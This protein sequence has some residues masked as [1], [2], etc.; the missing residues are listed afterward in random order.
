M[1]NEALLLDSTRPVST[2]NNDYGCPEQSS[3]GVLSSCLGSQLNWY[4][5]RVTYSRELKIKA[6]LE[7]K[8]IRTFVPM[9]YRKQIVDGRNQKKLVPAVNNLCFVCWHRQGIDDFIASYGEKSPVHYYW[10]RTTNRP[11]IVP[12]KAMEDFIKV[13]S[14]L[15]EDLIYITDI[16]DKLREGQEVKVKSGS[17]AG[18]TGKIVR[19]RKSRR[20]LVE[21]PG[22]L[23][24]AS[25]YIRPENV[26][27]IETI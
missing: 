26:E 3:Q 15:D 17:F 4:V 2:K 13:A 20:I 5:L 22:M 1:L 6:L 21:L 18:V 11:L 10:D 14:S 8:G 16:S 24:V 25:T 19:I 9:V 7:E 23:A 27:L 12:Q